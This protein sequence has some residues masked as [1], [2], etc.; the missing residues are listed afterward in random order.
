MI[1]LGV[2]CAL[3]PWNLFV[4]GTFIR[5][6]GPRAVRALEW[7]STGELRLWLGD[8]TGPHPACLHPAS[9]RL[10]LTFLVLWFTTSAGVRAVLIDG[11]LQNPVAFRR[12]C[13]A[14]TRGPRGS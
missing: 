13:R 1:R 5:L 11:G 4:L 8:G 9:F 12:L 10:G 14:L 2:C 3:C 6:R 7:A